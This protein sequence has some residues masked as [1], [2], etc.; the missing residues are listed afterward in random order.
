MEAYRLTGESKIGGINE[1]M[2]TLLDN[3]CKFLVFAHHISV[4]NG[5]E[6]YIKKQ[7][8]GYIRID[9]S[10]GIEQRH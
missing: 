6:D 7:K 1:F 3:G 8:V 2:D 4:M 5:L 9:G 10:V